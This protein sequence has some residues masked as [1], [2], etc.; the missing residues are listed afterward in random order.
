MAQFVFGP[1]PPLKLGRKPVTF[2]TGGGALAISGSPSTATVGQPF[3]FTPAVTGGSGARSFELTGTLPDGLSF[4]T[5]TGAI[6]GTP[7]TAGT[8]L[9]LSITVTD[10]SG[11][12]VL[13]PFSLTA[14][15][16]TY[17]ALRGL[18]A[19]A[20]YAALRGQTATGVYADLLG[21]AA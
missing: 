12:A 20:F 11:S 7:T 3:S 6:T 14:S 10:R 16:V 17:V 2:G 13:G 5:G 4:N 15:E 21:R 8:T 19:D 1:E 9:G 18:N